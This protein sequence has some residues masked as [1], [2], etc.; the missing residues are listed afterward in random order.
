MSNLM[1]SITTGLSPDISPDGLKASQRLDSMMVGNPEAM[2]RQ[3]VAAVANELDNYLD[4]PAFKEFVADLEAQGC[5]D[6]SKVSEMIAAT[7]VDGWALGS[8][9]NIISDAANEAIAE[10]FE[11]E[12][13]DYGGEFTEWDDPFEQSE[14]MAERF[15]ENWGF[16]CED[17][18]YPDFDELENVVELMKPVLGMWVEAQYRVT[19]QMLADNDIKEVA[20]FRGMGWGAD[21][22]RYPPDY[23]RVLGDEMLESG[24]SETNAS[25]IVEL[26]GSAA[27]SWTTDPAIAVNFGSS[28]QERANGEWSYVAAVVESTVPANKIFS[29]PLSGT[30]CLGEKEVVVIASEG[31]VTMNLDAYQKPGYDLSNILRR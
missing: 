17:E 15:M 11:M 13:A 27:A 7:I 2:K 10:Y 28:D 18:E 16:L 31:Q 29:L 12:Q 4:V 26:D 19:Q 20:L 5:P 9:N 30:G 21:S 14:V 6:I 22:E 25:L 1:P 24:E 8:N 3:A 23:L